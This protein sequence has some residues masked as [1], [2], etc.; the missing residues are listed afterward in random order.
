MRAPLPFWPSTEMSCASA[1]ARAR[2]RT[3]GVASTRAQ[4]VAVTPPPCR[5][6]PSP[7]A[8]A[9]AASGLAANVASYQLAGSAARSNSGELGTSART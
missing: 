8:R 5:G 9:G 4:S 1:H 7:A 6:W 2:S 3:S